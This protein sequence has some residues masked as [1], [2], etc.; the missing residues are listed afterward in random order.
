VRKHLSRLKGGRLA[1]A[2]QHTRLVTLMISDVVGDDPA[3][4]ASGPTVADPTT[5]A[6][7]LA[8]LERYRVLLPQR[9]R[10][11]L[12]RGLLETPKHLPPSDV[13]V[14]ARPRDALDTAKR[15]AQAAGLA[16]LD[17]GDRCEGFAGTVAQQHA[18]LAGR[19]A[20]G[21]GPVAPPCLILSG[22]ELTVRVVGAGRGGPNTEYALGLAAG[23][24]PGAWAIAADTDGTDGTADAAGAIVRPDTLSRALALGLRP[25][26]FQARSDSAAF[27]GPWPT[28]WKPG[29]PHKRQR[30]S[31]NSHTGQ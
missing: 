15:L 21:Q 6:A 26:D 30:L 10:D 19:I 22:G 27:S 8:V 16:V 5:C 24:P 18:D 31:R 28:W 17:L 3:V 23:L 11:D 9:I 2:A 12:A 14:I 20:A 25:A 1:L 13:A 7:A 4:I 29:R